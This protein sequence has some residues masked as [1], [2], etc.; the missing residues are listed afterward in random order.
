MVKA[1]RLVSAT[2]SKRVLVLEGR[3]AFTYTRTGMRRDP[4][5]QAVER[6]LVAIGAG[7]VDLKLAGETINL[8]AKEAE[9]E[10][11]ASVTTSRR[12]PAPAGKTV[13]TFT[14]W[15]VMG[16]LPPKVVVVETRA[17]NYVLSSLREPA[18]LATPVGTSTVESLPKAKPGRRPNQQRLQILPSLL[19]LPPLL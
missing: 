3:I 19:L 7:Q 18:N 13:P 10:R 16:P 1:L 12:V 14:K 4:R 15:N 9:A 17:R 8:P 2:T 6:A 11:L 5:P